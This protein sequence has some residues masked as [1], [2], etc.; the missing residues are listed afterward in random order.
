MIVTSNNNEQDKNYKFS[1]CTPC[2]NS[3]DSIEAVFTSLTNLE[4]QNFE[5]I[6]VN[7]ASSDNTSGLIHEMLNDAKFS[8]TFCDLDQNKMAT[9]CYHLAILKA[10]GE[11][12]IFL[13]HDDQ[14]KP[15]ALDRFLYQWELLSSNQQDNIAGMIAH[16]EDELGNLVGTNFPRSPDINSFFDLMFS[17]GVRG[18]KFFCYKTEIMQEN[19]FQLVDRYVPES[20]VMWRISAKYKTLF[21]NETLRIYTQPQIGGNNLSTMN[22]FDYP[23]GFRLSY[24]D[25]LNNFSNKLI[26]KPY[27]LVSFLF[28][29]SLF[30]CASHLSLRSSIVDL[31]NQ[32]HRV[33]IFPIFIVAWVFHFFRSKLSSN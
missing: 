18:E 14:I 27:L 2:Y 31:E 17:E 4:Y 24:L 7:D 30:S 16:C 23:L 11:F 21:F 26:Y 8:I 29:F 20:N 10:K 9:F 3:S 13:D 22:P 6:V 32:I 5:W 1:I 15:N 33:M 28:N 19:N 25:L 12:L